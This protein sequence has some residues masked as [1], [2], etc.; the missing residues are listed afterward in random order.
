MFNLINLTVSVYFISLILFGKYCCFI[1]LL[2]VEFKQC[3]LNCFVG[4][5]VCQLCYTI[6]CP[7]EIIE[8]QQP[9]L[10]SVKWFFVVCF[11]SC[12]VIKTLFLC[13]WQLWKLWKYFLYVHL[14]WIVTMQVWW[15]WNIFLIKTN[16]AGDYFDISCFFFRE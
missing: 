7:W 1:L 14:F 2:C 13:Y 5:V 4:Q 16:V 3:D 6:L 8:I 12:R 10:T 15:R 9:Y 11:C